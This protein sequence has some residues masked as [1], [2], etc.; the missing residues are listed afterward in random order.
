LVTR[1]EKAAQTRAALKK[2]ARELFAERG[3]VA[4]KIT[5][6]TA[7][8]GRATGSFYDHFVDKDALLRDLAADMEQQADEDMAVS[9]HAKDH[10]LTDRAELRRHVA[11]T[12]GVFSDHLPVIVALFQSSVA[13]GPNDGQAWRDLLRDTEVLAQHLEYLAERGHTLPG[14][15]RLVAA[16]M[17]GMFSMLGYSLLT[18]GQSRDSYHSDQVIDTLTDLLLF[19]LSGPRAT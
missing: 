13:R 18:A 17:G 6:I 11:V 12:W 5:D 14:D 9:E 7:A 8:A 10:D 16:A 19:G 1:S 4:T 2:A 15:P 3:F